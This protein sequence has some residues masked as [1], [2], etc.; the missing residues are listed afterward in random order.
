MAVIKG[1]WA[2]FDEVGR[3]CL[4]GSVIAAA[5][6]LPDDHAILGLTDS[7]KLSPRKR[8]ALA[9][10]I[11]EKAIAY[12]LGRAE[13]SE[14]DRINILNA[15][16]LAMERAFKALPIK[17]EVALVDGNRAPKLPI[18]TR[19]LV[20]GDGLEPSI[21][22]ASILAKVERD[23][24]MTLADSLFPGYGFKVHKG[25][26]TPLHQNALKALGP[27]PLHRK[28]FGPVRA[29]LEGGDP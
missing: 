5:V 22:A 17:P 18:E 19:T 15:S 4:A 2:G 12:A 28:S 11:R 23:L 21:S 20:G 6:I 29:V 27:S 24:E 25:Y 1:Y 8:E 13:P 10:E 16:L 7:K 9:E 14:I 26:P 3:G